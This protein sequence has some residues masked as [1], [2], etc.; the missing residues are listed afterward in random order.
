MR[1]PRASGREY[2]PGPSLGISLPRPP[3]ANP[4]LLPGPRFLEVNL[5]IICGTMPT[6]RKFFLHFTPRLL[7]G[8]RH[9]GPEGLHKPSAPYFGGSQSP[10]SASHHGLS[11]GRWA[12]YEQFDDT[13]ELASFAQLCRGDCAAAR[14]QVNTTAGGVHAHNLSDKAILQTRTVD[15]EY[16]DS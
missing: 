3:P 13:A 14:Y 7:Q 11:S 9:S 15:V 16:E 8:V 6:L 10:S 4:S 2:P 12:Y 1:P 5:L